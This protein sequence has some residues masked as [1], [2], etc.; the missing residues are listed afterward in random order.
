MANGNPMSRPAAI[1][2]AAGSV[3]G[4]CFV[5]VFGVIFVIPMFGP[6]ALIWIGG[7]VAI[8]LANFSVII[9]N[10]QRK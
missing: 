8:A 2:L 4:I 3:L 9:R 6:F 1:R 5:V 10:R 7:A